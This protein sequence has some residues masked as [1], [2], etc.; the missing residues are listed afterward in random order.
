[1][2]TATRDGNSRLQPNAWRENAEALADWAMTRLFVRR[3]VFGGYKPDG[4]QFTGRGLAREAV[5]KHFQGRQV[6]GAHTIGTEGQTIAGAADIDA[7][8]DQADSE[9]NL[10]FARRVAGQAQAYGLTGHVMASNG[11]GGYHV[12]VFFKSPVPS[13]VAHWLMKQLVADHARFGLEKP[14][15]VFPKQSELTISRPYGNWLRLPG[16]HHKR[17]FWTEILDLKTG[18]W[19]A[20]EQAVRYLLHIRGDD[21]KRAIEAYQ[22]TQKTE[23]DSAPKPQR[24]GAYQGNR[25]CQDDR[26]PTEAEIR[27]ALDHVPSDLAQDYEPWL[28]V[29]MAI[30][31]WDSGPTGLELWKSFSQQ[32]SGK[33]DANVCKEK[34]DTFS[35][36]GGLSYKLIFKEARN[37]GWKPE[38]GRRRQEDKSKNEHSNNNKHKEQP[39]FCNYRV[40]QPEE[41]NEKPKKEALSQP[42]LMAWLARLANG[43]PRRVGDANALFVPDQEEAVSYLVRPTQL[44]AW[45][46]QQARIVWGEGASYVSEARLFEALRQTAPKYEAIE[47]AP[48]FP[49]VPNVYYACRFPSEGGDGQA[50]EGLLDLFNPET[51]NDRELIRALVLTLFWGGPPGERPVFLTEGPENDP[52]GGRGVGKSRLVSIFARLVGGVVGNV[53][54]KDDISA[55]TKRIINDR[56]HK[57]CV[58]L[59]NVKAERFSWGDFEGLVTGETVGAWLNYVGDEIRPNRFTYA[60]TLNGAALSEDLAQRTVMIRLARPSYDHNGEAWATVIDR[61]IDEHRDRIMADVAA[62]FDRKPEPIKALQRWAVWTHEVLARCP[63]PHALQNLIL[64]RQAG[65]NDDQATADE[66]GRLLAERIRQ[67]YSVDP[68]SA[69]V[70][71]ASGVLVP[72]VAEFTGEKTALANVSKKLN[73]IRPPGLIKKDRKLGKGWLWTGSEANPE[74]EPLSDWVHDI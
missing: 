12:R 57:R 55:I 25:T 47:T 50:L 31:S 30:H 7:H 10:Q 35:Q 44:F 63:N 8:D 33:Y 72:I 73:R 9:A 62:V 59:D 37:N 38:R 4:G 34:W 71:I 29:G 67:K 54:A 14:P 45:V 6:I 70:W 24:N 66:F 15:E 69:C 3:D 61:Y 19:L 49:A 68:D 40:V 53:S 17:D 42:E 26:P 23:A 51:A 5:V 60:I 1:M 41:E 43:W 48:H 56:A 21:P 20:G 16:R 2:S 46:G 11:K 36:D 13:T 74:Q 27:D 39:V 64:K 18:R 52:R 58:L 28:N 22:Q 65:I 32:C